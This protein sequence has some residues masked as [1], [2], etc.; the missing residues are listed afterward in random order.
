MKARALILAL[1]ASLCTWADDAPTSVRTL[2]KEMEQ[3]QGVQPKSALEHGQR[4]LALLAQTPDPLLEME[5]RV[6]MARLQIQGDDLA[7]ARRTL[8]RGEQLAA[9][10]RGTPQ[11]RR[12]AATRVSLSFFEGALDKAKAEAVAARDECIRAQDYGPAIE[13]I[14]VLGQ[15]EAAQ[16]NFSGGIGH[17]QAAVEL[18]D[19]VNS[20]ERRQSLLSVLSNFYTETRDY[21]KALQANLDSMVIARRLGDP[22]RIGVLLL[23]GVNIRSK[24]GDHTTELADLKEAE[25]LGRAAGL[26]G[27]ILDADLGLTDIAIREGR[28]T[29]ALAKAQEALD[30]AQRLGT[31]VQGYA[32]AFARGLALARMGR[33]AQGFA[34][35]E[36]AAAR[37]KAS[38]LETEYQD[39]LLNLSEEYARIGDYRSAHARLKESKDLSDKVF[40]EERTR[41]L[42][43]LEARFQNER[44]AGEIARLK[45]QEQR[46]SLLRNFSILVAVLSLALVI[47]VISRLRASRRNEVV[48]EAR[49][50]ARTEAL[51]Q[52]Q[53]LMLRTQRLNLVATVGAGIAHDLNNLLTVITTLARQP[54]AR[55]EL[56]AV[57]HRA[58]NLARKTLD[59]G[60]RDVP[61][62]ELVEVGDLLEGLEPMLRRMLDRGI[63]LTI[64]RQGGECWMEVDPIHLEQVVVNLVTNARDAL[65]GEGHLRIELNRDGDLCRLEVEDDGEGMPEEVRQR[66]FDPFFTTKSPGKGTGLGLPS[67]LAFVKGHHGAVEVTSSPGQGTRFSLSLPVLGDL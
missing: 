58:A 38:N 39:F 52:A 31:T 1:L 29:E 62:I 43:E 28:Y 66:I 19:K 49:V 3:L 9:A 59:L 37:F 8:E 16:G 5:V 18:C 10:H 45:A 32:A 42:A 35:M 36:Q 53:D 4:I 21:Q 57:A 14:G 24:L 50:Q 54:E 13:A 22:R 46:R 15:A 61:K 6:D 67:I 63:E 25:A 40:S 60:G 2:R 47:A 41:T 65:K 20:P 7:S 27:I 64:R 30:R 44:Q 12:I 17:L 34:E 48:L 26:E 55:E 23:N 51:E 56:E 11:A 33:H